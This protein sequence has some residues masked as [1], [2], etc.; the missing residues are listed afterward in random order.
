[1]PNISPI[2]AVNTQHQGIQTVLD[3]LLNRGLSTEDDTR[4]FASVRHDDLIRTL[5]NYLNAH[6]HFLGYCHIDARQ[7]LNDRGVDV[8]L[9][10]EGADSSNVGI[11]SRVSV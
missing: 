10:S 1:M 7:A 2:M 11:K 3:C 9:S 4:W 6:R 5:L 8:V